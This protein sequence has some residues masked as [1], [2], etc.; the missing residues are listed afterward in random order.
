V[1]LTTD[2]TPL[3]AA[4]AAL[5]D[6]TRRAVIRALLRKPL[7]AGEL[8]ERVAMSPPALTRHLRVL[9]EAGLIVEDGVE[10]DARVR[11]YTVD[12]NAFAPVKDWL[13][14]IEDLWHE[15]LQAFKEH[16]ERIQRRPRK[17]TS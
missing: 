15:Q 16:A 2:A 7:R 14:Q 8:A 13:G 6:P 9:R 17:P 4:F 11:V 12:L 3:D 1:S 5:S 10:G